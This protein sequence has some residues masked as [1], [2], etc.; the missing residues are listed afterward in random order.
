MEDLE[1]LNN[2]ET[3]A[4]F[5]ELNCVP[6]ETAYDSYAQNKCVPSYVCGKFAILSLFIM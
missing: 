4:K 5:L 1:K 3:K 2:M 6:A